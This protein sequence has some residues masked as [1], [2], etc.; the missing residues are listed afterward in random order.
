MEE[1][2]WYLFADDLILY[3]ENPEEHTHVPR[4][5]WP[6]W[7]ERLPVDRKVCIW[8]PVRAHAQAG[9]SIPGSTSLRRERLMFLSHI[10]VCL[11]SPVSPSPFLFLSLKALGEKCPWVKVLKIKKNK[12]KQNP[13]AHTQL[14]EL[15]NKFS[16][17]AEYKTNKKNQ[18]ISLH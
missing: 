12:T 7:S 16:K 4:L 15:F 6:R 3:I 5:V 18:L 9:G 14:L 2:K 1:L 8:F 17:A 10:S 11:S 13:H